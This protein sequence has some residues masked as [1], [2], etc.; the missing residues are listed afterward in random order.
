MV[1]A[2]FAGIAF[3]GGLV[4]AA[5]TA[6]YVVGDREIA[7]YR[8]VK[9]VENRL[10]RM[11]GVD[12]RP[13]GLEA[14]EYPTAL[15]RLSSRIARL[16][17]QETYHPVAGSGGGLSA[18]G[19]DVLL[20]TFDGRFFA[21]SDE[22]TL[23]ELTIE[24]PDNR[25]DAYESLAADPSLAHLQIRQG[26]LR[27]NDVLMVD[28]EGSGDG[29]LRHLVLS[30]TDF[31][32][33]RRCFRNAVA[34]ADIAGKARTADDLAITV[35]DWRILA[36][37]EPCLEMKDRHFAIEGHMAGGRMAFQAPS[38]LVLTSGDFH[39]DGM[40]STPGY[41]I[42]QDPDAQYGKILGIDIDSGAMRTMSSGHRNPQGVT[43]WTDGTPMVVEHGPRGGDEI[44][45][46]RD[47]ANYG[48]PVESL[49]TGY[50]SRGP[51]PGSKSFGRHDSFP[52]PFYAWVPSIAPSAIAVARGVHPAW[53]GDILVTSLI[54]QSLH[55][56][57]VDGD[58]VLYSERIP[59]G[60][61]LRD[62]QIHDDGRLVLWTDNRE[63]VF[64][65]VAD[66]MSLDNM[67][68][69]IGARHGWSAGEREKVTDAASV[70]AECHAFD[71]DDH[72]KAPGMAQIFGAPIASTPFEGYSDALRGMDGVWDEDRLRAF[73]VDPDS[74]APGTS[75]PASG[76]TDRDTIDRLIVLMKDMSIA[77]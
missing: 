33:E 18:F 49:G 47:G 14:R 27:Y 44:N 70:C 20:V 16:P 12:D 77:Y 6:G 37:T 40:R 43:L 41:A 71:P 52:A 60:A 72:Q 21:A 11:V 5:F 39:I 4:G 19:R 36:M 28:R 67:I 8:F 68:S 55:R 65:T 23:R 32:P 54:D 35:Q 7:P 58:R 9:K 75:M 24:A 45:M 34:V 63:L 57:R 48:W 50:E 59:I 15:L 76:L 26:Y 13:A 64:L 22:N 62:I 42:A 3:A 73:I 38:T 17:A 1:L 29:P 10:K 46:I 56:I 61:R 74:V 51:L 2:A 53:E 31:D 30:Y 66:Y 69:V 25:R